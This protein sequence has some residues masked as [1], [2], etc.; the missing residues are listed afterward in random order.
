MNLDLYWCWGTF[1]KLNSNEKGTG[2]LTS[3]ALYSPPIEIPGSWIGFAYKRNTCWLILICLFDGHV[4]S[5]TVC[6]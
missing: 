2:T 3:V 1:R 6:E 4:R 5:T